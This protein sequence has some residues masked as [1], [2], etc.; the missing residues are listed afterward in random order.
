[1]ITGSLGRGGMGVVYQAVNTLLNRKAAVKVLSEA[2]AAQPDVRRRFLREAK[3]AAKLD[4]PNVVGIYEVDQR[5]GTYYI[6]M[7]LVE[8][9]SAEDLV[10]LRGPL[11]WRDA[12]RWVADACRGL[13]AAHGA[14]LIH[15]DIKPA[16]IIR[17][18]DGVAKLLDFG[19]AKNSDPGESAITQSGETVGTPHY[20]SPEQC[21]CRPLDARSDLYSLGATYYELLTGKTPYSGDQTEV[22]HGHLYVPPPDPRAADAAIPA[23]CSAVVTRAMAKDLGHRYQAARHML[24]DLEKILSHADGLESSATVRAAAWGWSPLALGRRA[25]AWFGR[26]MGR[27]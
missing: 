20:M 24:A 5:D 22:V 18:H 23:A 6:A 17:G 8:G 15:R 1:M 4:H 12:T 25:I 11:N 16:N 19:L 26:L 13:S 3:A 9:V 10:R 2:L 27:P 7:E 21:Q 14:G